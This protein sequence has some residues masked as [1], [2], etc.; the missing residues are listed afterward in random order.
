STLQI[1]SIPLWLRWLRAIVAS[2]LPHAVRANYLTSFDQYRERPLLYQ[3]QH[4]AQLVWGAYRVLVV[5]TL[6]DGSACTFAEVPLIAYCFLTA[7]R[8]TRWVPWWIL[9]PLTA[10]LV[11]L[12]L[13][14]IWWYHGKRG[15]VRAQLPPLEKYYLESSMDALC[16]CLFMFLAQGLA[17]Y[18]AWAVQVPNPVLFRACAIALPA[19]ALLRMLLRPMPDP[20]SPFEGKGMSAVEMYHATS[21]LNILWG[22]CYCATIM[23]GMSD[24]PYYVPDVLRGGLPVFVLV[25]F[26]M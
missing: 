25:N 18:F 24:I 14:D 23:M 19:I 10:M 16:A 20:K 21:R 1:E 6:K 17:W 5:P 13:R 4:A 12:S 2:L 11:G 22:A 3:M 8:S 26:V 7:V 9:L 15:R